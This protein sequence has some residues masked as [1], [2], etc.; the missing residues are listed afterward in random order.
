MA[1][2][3]YE[4]NLLK[5]CGIKPEQLKALMPKPATK[6]DKA[7]PPVNHNLVGMS[8][9]VNRTCQCCMSVTTTYYNYIK[10]EDMEGFAMKTVAKPSHEV[11]RQH[12]YNVLICENCDN[13]KLQKAD[14]KDLINMIFSLRAAAYTNKTKQEVPME[15][16]V[17]NQREKGNERKDQKSCNQQ[18]LWWVW[19][20]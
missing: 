8:A 7:H 14:K 4:L 10:R 13:D 20:K 17:L 2:T 3:E 12:C 16:T 15:T 9:K 1:L 11:T 6:S 18:V 19:L 5:D